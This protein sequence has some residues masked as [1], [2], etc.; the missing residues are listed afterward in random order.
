MR[1]NLNPELSSVRCAVGAMNDSSIIT[2]YM[3]RWGMPLD[4]GGG[5][6]REE[7]GK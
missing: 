2:Y 5:G 7:E 1:F 6:Q 3:D 4:V